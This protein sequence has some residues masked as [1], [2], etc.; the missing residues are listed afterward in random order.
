M[1]TGT[2]C[3]VV[4]DEPRIRGALAR[5]LEV[6]GYDCEQ[7]GSGIEA[8]AAMER[9]VFPIVLSDIRMPGMDGVGLLQLIRERWPDTAMLMLS[10]VAEVETAVACLQAGAFDYLPKPF[11][12]GEVRAR[13][14]QALEKRRLRLENREYQHHLADMVDQQALRIE[15]LFLEGVQALAQA[16]EAKDPYTKGHSSR[17]A[18]YAGNV[19]R[20]LGLSDADAALVELGAELHDVGKI[21]VRETV[22]QKPGPLTP[23][24]YA[25]IMEHPVIG[26]RILG[27]L[28][29][30]APQVL[31]IVR[32]H[33]ER[34]DGQ[35]LPDGLSGEAI[36]LHARIVAVA[37]AFDAMTTGRPYRP[38][39]TVADALEE[40]RRGAGTQW[41]SAVV[42][43][44]LSMCRETTQLPIATP[45]AVRRRIPSRVAAGG[46]GMPTQ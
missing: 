30:H 46:I 13:V 20:R 34:V 15:E 10:A 31:A 36:S 19:A 26:A 40:M 12:V 18:A 17:V 29:K 2:R 21:G 8:V 14:A 23:E 43:V 37:D 42:D 25:H 39:R 35:G 41:D 4:D 11:Q 28:L 7:A 1:T 3:L 24:E 38:Q 9:E 33:H 6:A 5:L 16:L 27:P 45:P 22:L 32:S 44:F